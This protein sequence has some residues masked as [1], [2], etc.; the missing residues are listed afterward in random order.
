[1]KLY[2]HPQSGHAFKVKFCLESADISHEYEIVDIFSD[3]STRAEEFLTKSKFFEVPLLIDGEKNIVQSNAIL[4]Y[5]ASKFNIYG[6][7]DETTW[8]TCL[9]WLFWESNKIGMCLPQL[10]ADKSFAG[11]EL[12]HDARDWLLKRFNLDVAVLES[13]L[14]DGRK[15]LV[16]D[17]LTIADFSI[18]GYL[19]Y[20]NEA[21]VTIPKNVGSW[22]ARLANLPS[23]AH[24]YDM[25]G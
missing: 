8:N 9:Q 1:M 19:F 12:S 3:R 18:C 16:G 5:I 6:H 24:P 25:L 17:Q 13:E 21:D 23:W 22:I 20:Q 15:F 14:E 10:R 4:V 11:F 7:E 2:G